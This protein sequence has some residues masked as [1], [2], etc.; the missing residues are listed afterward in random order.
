MEAYL[1]D[2]ITPAEMAT[3]NNWVAACDENAQL[4]ER[5]REVWFSMS[6][7]NRNLVI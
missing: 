5:I 6:A 1:T 7:A 4:F 3:L 2:T